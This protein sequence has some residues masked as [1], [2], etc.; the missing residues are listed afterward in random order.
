LATDEWILFA[1]RAHPIIHDAIME[2]AQR[3]GI[4]PKHMHD[5]HTTQQAVHLVSEHVGVAIL[6]K[7][8]V[9][10]SVQGVVVKPLSDASLCFETCVIMRSDNDSRLANEFARSFIRRYELQRLPPKQMELSLSA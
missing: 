6:T 5:I 3:E 9:V 2:A 7:P 1:R 10:V 4:A 8:A